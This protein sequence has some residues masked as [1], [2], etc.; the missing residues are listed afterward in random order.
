[1]LVVFNELP[2]GGHPYE[3]FHSLQATA[4]GDTTIKL[5]NVETKQESLF[6]G[7]LCSVKSVRFQRNDPRMSPWISCDCEHS[8]STPF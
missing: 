1:M 3:F 2:E 5:L 6:K 4:A 7:H 8:F